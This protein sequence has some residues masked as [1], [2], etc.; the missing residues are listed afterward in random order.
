MNPLEHI[1]A[2]VAPFKRD[3]HPCIE[4]C[5]RIGAG[6]ALDSRG[7]CPECGI[8][9]E[10]NT[11]P[12]CELPRPLVLLMIDTLVAAQEL[13]DQTSGHEEADVHCTRDPVLKQCMVEFDEAMAN[14]ERLL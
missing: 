9:T 10:I 2:L 7:R 12:T 1:R 11:S 5:W 6:V 8:P 13:R 3:P 14:L 4:R